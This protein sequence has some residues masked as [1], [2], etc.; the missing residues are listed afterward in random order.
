MQL[1]V[2]ESRNKEISTL[3]IIMVVT[4]TKMKIFA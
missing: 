3:F 1:D 4:I 2:G